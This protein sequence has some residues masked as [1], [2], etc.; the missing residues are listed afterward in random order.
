[1]RRGL[2]RI[3]TRNFLKTKNSSKNDELAPVDSG[4]GEIPIRLVKER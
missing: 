4:A 3:S 1:M 2:L